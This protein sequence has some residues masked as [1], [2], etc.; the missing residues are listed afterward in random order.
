M[1]KFAGLG[2]EDKKSFSTTGRVYGRRADVK[3]VFF[4]A[5]FCK[6]WQREQVGMKMRESMRMN[7]GSSLF[8]KA[9]NTMV[10]FIALVSFHVIMHATTD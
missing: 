10:F 4:L 7:M 9:K 2:K 6:G 1:K 3:G 5:M 8:H